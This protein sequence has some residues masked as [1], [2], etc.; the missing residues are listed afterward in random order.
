MSLLVVAWAFFRV[1]GSAFNPAVT[2]ALYLVGNLS[3]RRAAATAV[4]QLLGG[5]AAA[6]AAKGLTIGSFG[7]TNT[8]S[9]G[10]SVGRIESPSDFGRSFTLTFLPQQGQGL[11]IEMFTTS[12]LVFSVLM[13]AAEK[14][15]TTFLAPVAIGLSLFVGHLAS[16]GWTGA[17]EWCY[18]C[19]HALG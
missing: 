3:A 13:L 11:G 5:I 18:C 10:V 19:L 7:V 15:K 16:V 12:L 6:G 14:S 2:M 1:C 4:A 8:L 9:A 17:G